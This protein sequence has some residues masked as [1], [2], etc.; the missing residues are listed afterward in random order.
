[1]KRIIV[2][3]NCGSGKSTFAEKLSQMTGIPLTHLDQLYW[4]PNWVA[5][6]HDEFDEKIQKIITTDSWILDGNYTRSA[7]TRI[8]KSDTVFFFDFPVWKS[9]FRVV[10]RSIFG[11]GKVQKG[12]AEECNE[13][14][15][16]KFYLYV[17]RFKQHSRPLIVKAIEA[18]TDQLDVVVFKNNKE[19]D[20]WLNNLR[21]SDTPWL[22]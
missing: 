9:L 10:K 20:A 8:E 7:H 13:N 12:A 4:K 15:D 22:K 3:G 16:L 17:L 19:S 21:T 11:Y 5:S 6:D 2:I 18:C 1:M 14:Y